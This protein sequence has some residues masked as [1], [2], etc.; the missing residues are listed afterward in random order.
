M[1]DVKEGIVPTVISGIEYFFLPKSNKVYI[2]VATARKLYQFK[3][4][5]PSQDDRPWFER[6]FSSYSKDTNEESLS[7]E[8]QGMYSQSEQPH[9][10]LKIL[11]DVNMFFPKSIGYLADT[12][13][14]IFN[15]VS[16][17]QALKYFC[18]LSLLN[19]LCSCRWL[20]VSPPR[21]IF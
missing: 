16:V 4:F 10:R 13:D 17:L 2:M 19:V 12:G 6:I 7:F 18:H 1:Y 20:K 8:E 15:N 3:G 5:V 11:Y 14:L 9:C 21:M